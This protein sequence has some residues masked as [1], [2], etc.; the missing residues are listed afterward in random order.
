MFLTNPIDRVRDVRWHLWRCARRAHGVGRDRRQRGRVRRCRRLHRAGQHRRRR[1]R[2]RRLRAHATATTT[3]PSPS[4]PARRSP[5]AAS[6]SPTPSASAWA[7]R[8]RRGCSTPANTPARQLLLD[9]ARGDDL[10][11]LPG[12]HRRDRRAPSSPTPGAANDCFR[13]RRRLARRHRGLG[14]RR[15]RTSSARTSAG[16]PTSPPARAPRACCGRCATAPSTLFRLVYDGAQVGAGHDQR[17][18]DGKTL[19]YP[20]GGGVP[21]AEGM[22]LVAGDP[23]AIFVS[24]ERNDDGPNSNT[25]RPDVLRYDITG[26]GATLTA[27]NDWDLTLDLPGLAD[28]NAGPRG[29]RLGAGQPARRQGLHDDS[30]GTAYNPAD[31][32]RPRHRPVLRRRR[33]DRQDLSPTRSTRPPNTYTR[34]ADDRQRVPDDHGPRVRPRDHPPVGGV[35]QQLQR[36]DHDAGH[37][38][39]RQV[40]RHQHVRPSG[41][42]AEPQQR[43][44]HDRPAG[45][46]R[47]TAS[48]RRSTPTTPTAAA[49]RCAPARST[50]RRPRRPTRATAA[51]AVAAVAAAVARPRRPRRRSRSSSRSCCPTAPRRRWRSS[52]KVAKT[53]RKDGKFSVVDHARREGRPDDHRDRAQERQGQGPDAD[54]DD[55]QGRRRGQ[56]DGQADADQEG[57]Q[58]PAQGRDADA[59][60]GRARRGGQRHDEDGQGEGEVVPGGR[61]RRVRRRPRGLRGGGAERERQR[62]AVRR[63]CAAG[64]W[65]RSAA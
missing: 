17:L 50:A 23:N 55:P 15:R 19:V 1:G 56:A 28:A 16:S 53:V 65:R 29:D 62:L 12:R 24:T 35:R 18:G 5:A 42:H 33:G 7:P 25:S 31:L 44:L 30:A 14:G 11:P 40:R 39:A 41:G 46:V 43:G 22:T 45:R 27:T 8:T 9:R 60:R 57:P 59:D 48:S 38:L 49:T 3:T 47:R 64:R 54:Q 52:L 51:P 63:P 32:R 37:R 26:A 10:R 58:G 36:P 2:H 34:V 4:R 61:R 6:T 13:R 21:D 20:D